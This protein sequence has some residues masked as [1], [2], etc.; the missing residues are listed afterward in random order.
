MSNGS[1]SI[2]NNEDDALVTISQVEIE[3]ASVGPKI[4]SCCIESSFITPGK[5]KSTPDT[6]NIVNFSTLN[7]SK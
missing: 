2:S 4:I 6:I 3:N 7:N 5:H 1:E